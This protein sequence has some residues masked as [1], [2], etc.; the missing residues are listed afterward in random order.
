MC[1]MPAPLAQNLTVR[2]N[3]ALEFYAG[4]LARV[5]EWG[6][7]LKRFGAPDLLTITLLSLVTLLDTSVSSAQPMTREVALASLPR[8]A[9]HT[10][11]L[12]G[13][14]ALKVG[15]IDDRALARRPG[16]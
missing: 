16:A 14:I 10:P 9:I 4:A 5:F 1:G 7:R 2:V 3:L 11:G 15:R 6:I 12:R 13:S 8:A